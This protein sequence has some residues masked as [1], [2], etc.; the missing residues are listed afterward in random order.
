MNP[1]RLD[2]RQRRY[3]S[4]T[5]VVLMVEITKELNI[6]VKCGLKISWKVLNIISY[7]DDTVFLTPIEDRLHYYFINSS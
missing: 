2:V 6:E 5:V 1:G 7:A 3:P 4:T